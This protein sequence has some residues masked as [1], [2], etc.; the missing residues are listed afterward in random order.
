MSFLLPY[1]PSVNNRLNHF[2]VK[3]RVRAVLKKPYRQ[4][5]TAAAE[6]IAASPDAFQIKG[7]YRLD[8]IV[9][10]PDRRARDLDNIIKPVS[11]ALTEAGVIEDDSLALRITVRWL[12][13]PPQ[14]PG[15]IIVGVFPV[16]PGA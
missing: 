15:W 13:G 10:R 4:W 7:T 11:D 8:L 6:T 12:D 14:P 9:C 5:K 3:G 16:E 1:P 2:A